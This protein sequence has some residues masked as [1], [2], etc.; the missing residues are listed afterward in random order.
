MRL[1]LIFVGRTRKNYLSRGV[2]E[3]LDRIKAYLPAEKIIIKETKVRNEKEADKIKTR[4]T[5]RLMA[6]LKKDDVFVL[7]DPGGRSMTSPELARWLKKQINQGRSAIVF[8][9][10]GPLGF[11]PDARERADMVLSLSKMTF[12]HEM[13][14]LILLEQIY[15][16][17][18]INAG[19]PY[20]K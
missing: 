13:S 3:Y 20:H 6:G 8:G 4:D 9:L 15:R 10:G 14:R 18:T 7:L 5:A 19:H 16:A 12:T 1:K 11:G 17:L 2:S